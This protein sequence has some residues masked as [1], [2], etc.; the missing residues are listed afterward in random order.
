MNPG[1][2]DNHRGGRASQGTL[3]RGGP[4]DVCPCFKRR[5]NHGLTGCYRHDEGGSRQSRCGVRSSILCGA[6]E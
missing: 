3:H 5:V 6:V 2:G 4:Q 1:L